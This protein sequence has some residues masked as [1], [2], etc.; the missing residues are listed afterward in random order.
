M[1]LRAEDYRETLERAWDEGRDGCPSLWS[2]CANLKHVAHSLRSWSKETFG[3]IR[4]RIGR[5][6]RRIATIQASPSS[7]SLMEEERS[8]E[9]Q[10][11]ELFEREEIMEQQRSCIDWLKAGDRNTDFFHAKASARR[12]TNRIHSLVREDGT[13]CDSQAGIKGMV[14]GY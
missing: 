5:L 4:K 1:W 6:E 3:F 2:T 7:P 14:Q 10:L 13:S 11:C 12:R 8:I 9:R